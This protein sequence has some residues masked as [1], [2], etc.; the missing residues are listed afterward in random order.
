MKRHSG[1]LFDLYEHP[2]KGVVLWLAGEDGKPYSFHQ[3][4]ETVFYARGPVEQLHDLG[5]FIRRRYSK[6]IVSLKRATKD[7]LFDGPQVVMGIDVSTS[8][9]YKKLIREVQENFPDLIY[10]DVDVP[11]TVR[12]AAA[13]NVFMLARCEVMTEEGGRIISIRTLDTPYDLDPKLPSLR[14]LSLRPDADPSFKAPRYLAIRFGKSYLRLPL[15]KPHELLSILNGIFSSYDPDV[16]HTHFGDSWLLP[17][18]LELSRKTGIPFTPNRDSSVPVLRR[19]AVKFFNYGRAHYR[20]PQ[21]H[22]RGRWHI[23]VE[24]CVSYNQYHL[25]GAIEQTRLSSLP[26]Q[27]V[28][29]RSPGAAISAMQTL[30]ALKTNILIPYQSQKAEIAKS[31]NE[32]YRAARGG[33]ILQPPIGIYGNIAVMDF[34][35]KMASIMIKYNVSPETVVSIDDPREGFNIPEL[36]VKILSRPGLIPQTLQP[37]RDKRLAL[38]KLLKSINKKD[39]KYHDTRRRYRLVAKLLDF[40]AVTDALKWLT[41]VCYGRLRFANSIFGRINS[42]E[43]VSYLSRKAIIQAKRIAEARGGRALHL[44]VDSVFV[45]LPNATKEDFQALANEIAEKTGLPM[46]LENVYCWFAF[47][48]SRQNPNISVANKFFGIAENGDHKIRGI[49][50]RRGNTCTFV[51]NIQRQMIEIMAKEKDPGRLGSL[52]PE[53][54]TMIQEKFSALKLRA[55]EPEELVISQRLSRDLDGYSVLSPTAVAAKQLQIQGTTV[56]RGQQVRFI[57]TA[58]GPGV[59]AWNMSTELDRRDIDVRQYK[60]LGF[61]AIH[62]ILQPLGVRER[63]LKDWIF[64]NSGYVMPADLINP[65]QQIVKQELPLLADLRYLRVDKF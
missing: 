5:V 50:V 30:T 10:Y 32:F 28:A 52:L 58:P 45:S 62:E 16:I 7:D 27:E 14:L 43:V 36:K 9:I 2:T 19:K 20:A 65:A 11:F 35:S 60:E 33:L 6:E 47:L 51:A 42:H 1:W 38:K 3:E 44:Y 59:R 40:E 25:I 48:N 63:V 37:M 55:V 13:H 39:P 56:Q 34:S 4:F 22:L 29:R 46:E 8:G 24:N 53:I 41:V 49:A 64:N 54:L 23:D 61:R 26:L 15:D 31:F 17:H 21:V 12:Y 18:L 57:Y